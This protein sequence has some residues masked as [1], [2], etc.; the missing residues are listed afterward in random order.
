MDNKVLEIDSKI[1][2]AVSVYTEVISKKVI[3]SICRENNID[4]SERKAKMALQIINKH[5]DFIIESIINK[6]TSI[7][8][9]VNKNNISSHS[10]DIRIHNIRSSGEVHFRFL[11]I[12]VDQHEN[13]KNIDNFYIRINNSLKMIIGFYLAGFLAKNDLKKISTNLNKIISVSDLS[14]YEY[15]RISIKDLNEYFYIDDITNSLHF[16]E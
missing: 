5:D 4:C 12:L 14:I 3:L 7:N 11:K 13:F 1:I 8:S 16:K 10:Q 15:K 6:K 9:W 2:Q